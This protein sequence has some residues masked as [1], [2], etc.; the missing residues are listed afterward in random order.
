MDQS[1]NGRIPVPSESATQMELV[2]FALTFNGYTRNSGGSSKIAPIANKIQA[3]F[4]K[5]HTFPDDL[6]QLR[7]ALFWEQRSLRNNEEFSRNAWTYVRFHIV[8]RC[9]AFA[10]PSDPKGLRDQEDLPALSQ[11]ECLILRTR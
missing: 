7:T 8:Q 11:F 3:E 2:E 6:D 4:K 10:Q 5:S 9:L 1:R